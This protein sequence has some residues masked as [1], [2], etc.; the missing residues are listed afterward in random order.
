MSAFRATIGG[1]FALLA[2][3]VDEDAELDSMVT[4][5]NKALTDTAAELLGKQRRK[6]KPWV[7]PEIL[8]LCDQ[9]RDLKKKRGE[10]EEAKDYREIKRKIRTEMKM[11][12]ETWIQG[13]CQEVEACLRK[14]NSK[15]AY[16]L[17]KDLTT[18]KQGKSTTKTSREKCRTEENEILNRWTEYCSDLYNYETDGDPIVLD[19]PQISDEEHHPILREEVEAAVKALKMGK[20]A[21]VDNIPA[22]LVQAGGEAMIDILTAI[23]NKIWKTGEW[24]TTWTQSLVITLPKEGNLQL[25]Q[26]YRTISLIS[27]PSKVMLKIILNR[28]QPQAEEIIAEEQAG[29]RAGRSTTEQI[30]NLCEKYLQH[31]QS[32][33]HVFIDFKKAFDR[34]WHEALWAT[35]RKYSINASIIRAI[36]NLNDK[37]QSAV[38]FKCSTGEWFRTTVGVRQGCLLSPTL[39]NIFQER[40]MCEALDDHEG[41]VSIGGRLITN[42]RFAD[43]IVVNAE[44]EEEA[45]VLIDRLDRTT[46]RYK[47]EIGPDK[48]KVMTNNPNGFQ[49]E[50]KIKGQRLEEVENFKYLGAIISNEGS[51]PEILSRIAQTTAVL[52]RLKIIWRDKNISLAS[53]VKLMRTLILSTFLYACESGTLTAEIES[54][55]DPFGVHHGNVS[56]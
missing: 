55:Q 40:I 48:T 12:K 32:L 24:P 11:A 56:V 34:V 54:L 22:E 6:R 51:K 31:Q 13:Q 19:C 7:T 36:E 33:Y 15:K 16:Q 42:F 10:P 26:N 2:T 45:G 17:V 46:T 53:K 38:L 4:H 39:F 23:C 8:D 9:R 35:M 47:M 27:H 3:L 44:E 25:C 21:G 28:L 14:N 37:A 43:D 50:I 29:F 18:E 20:S 30:F 52:S 49:R 5:F 41:S 1:R